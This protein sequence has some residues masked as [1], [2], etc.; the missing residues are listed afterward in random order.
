VR[1]QISHSNKT[2]GKITVMYNLNIWIANWKKKDS[3]PNDTVL[4]SAQIYTPLYF[5][6]EPTSK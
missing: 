6:R 5:G 2:T 3:A 1:E 4:H